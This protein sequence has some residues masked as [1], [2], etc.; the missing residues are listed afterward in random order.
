MR[1]TLEVFKNVDYDDSTW[2]KD[3]EIRWHRGAAGIGIIASHRDGTGY[4]SDESER[5]IARFISPGRVMRSARE[6]I[7]SG[8]RCCETVIE[9]GASKDVCPTCSDKILQI[10]VYRDVIWE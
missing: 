1:R 5:T 6:L 8:V 10:A 9:G 4:A 7:A 2:F 3:V